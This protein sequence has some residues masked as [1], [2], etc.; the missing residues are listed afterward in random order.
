MNEARLIR[1]ELA[2]TYTRGRLCI[3]NMVL[4]TM[5][6]PWLNNQIGKSCIPAGEYEAVMR[7]S[8]K[9]GWKYW[10]QNTDPRTFVLIHGGNLARHTMGC[11][12]PGKRKGTLNGKAAVLNSKAAV[13]VIHDYFADQPFTLRIT[14]E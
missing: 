9:Y 10:L 7:K 5:E 8:P 2:D 14:N 11:I 4:H 12:L 1:Y 3:G 6:P 13:R